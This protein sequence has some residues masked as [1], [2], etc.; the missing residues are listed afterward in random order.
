MKERLTSL[1]SEVGERFD[2]LRSDG[3]NLSRSLAEREKRI[4]DYRTFTTN[5]TFSTM[6]DQI[7]IRKLLRRTLTVL[8]SP[9]DRQNVASGPQASIMVEVPNS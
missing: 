5:A 6:V 3:K 4:E 8:R 7:A 2:Y 9:P 1:L